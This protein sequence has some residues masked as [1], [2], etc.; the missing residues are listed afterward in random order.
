MK[1]TLLILILLGFYNFS[2]AQVY[3]G[4]GFD[5]TS[6]QSFWTEY[7]LGDSDMHNWNYAPSTASQPFCLNHDYPM[8]TGTDSVEDWMV[9]NALYLAQS[10]ILNVKI[11]SSR[12]SS[13]PD[14]YFGIWMSDGSKNPADSDFVE[15]VDLTLFPQT[16]GFVDTSFTIPISADTGYIAFKYTAGYYEWLMVSIDDLAIMGAYPVGL[17]S[18][19]FNNSSVQ[20]YPNPVYDYCTFEIKNYDASKI[21]G[22][23]ELEIY[24]C[25]GK[26]V[27]VN[28]YPASN[29]FKFHKGNLNSGLY[30]YKIKSENN[31]IYSG[32]LLIE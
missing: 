8:T 11:M 30:F 24:D 16:F 7:R 21:Q 2:N 26:L 31:I 6:E 28:Y 20:V 15:I 10:G 4:T 12:M 9:S 3:W 1:K 13:P 19:N 27:K 32:K 23:I 29:S 18:K 5:S 22:Q 25:I 17:A 14:V